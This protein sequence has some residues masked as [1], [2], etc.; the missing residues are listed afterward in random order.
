M[1][2]PSMVSS[3]DMPAAERT[4]RQRI[5]YGLI[6]AGFRTSVTARRVEV[7]SRDLRGAE[8]ARAVRELREA[9]ADDDAAPVITSPG[10]DRESPTARVPERVAD[11]LSISR[12]LSSAI[13]HCDG[14]WPRT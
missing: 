12:P 8:A 14:C 4:G 5:A 2:T 11:A 1:K 10:R 7:S 13:R 3:K 6:V 9:L